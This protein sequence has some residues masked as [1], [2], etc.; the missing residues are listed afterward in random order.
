VYD[1]FTSEATKLTESECIE[2]YEKCM[3][4]VLDSKGKVDD[5]SSLPKEVLQEYQK[6]RD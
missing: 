3:E 1:N 2:T 5:D 4:T 6:N